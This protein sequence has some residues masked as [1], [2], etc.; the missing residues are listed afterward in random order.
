VPLTTKDARRA[1]PTAA[2]VMASFDAHEDS[3]T[4]SPAVGLNMVN[5]DGETLEDSVHDDED[6][7]LN[8]FLHG[9]KVLTTSVVGPEGERAPG[10]ETQT[11]RMSTPTQGTWGSS[12]LP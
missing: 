5:A 6:T 3:G 4:A 2:S 12:T 10:G 7:T 8:E 1:R 11:S 9:T